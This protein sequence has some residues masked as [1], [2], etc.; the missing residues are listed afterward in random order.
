MSARRALSGIVACVI[1]LVAIWIASF[2]LASFQRAD[3][4]VFLAFYDLTYL[5]YP[6]RPNP[7]FSFL[8]SLCHALPYALIAALVVA[9]AL[10]R[11]Q[12]RAAC[13]A[14]IVLI[15]ANL[16]TLV[17]KA[18]L[19]EPRVATLVVGAPHVPY[20]RWPSGHSTAAMAVALA[21]VF[22]APARL[23]PVAAAAGGAFVALVADGLLVLGSHLPSDVLAGFLVAAGW[24][25]IALIAVFR[26]EH[27]ARTR[28]RHSVRAVTLG[29]SL[30]LSLSAGSLVLVSPEAIV[31]YAGGHGRFVAV[32]LGVAAFTIATCMAVAIVL[33]DVRRPASRA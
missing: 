4:H 1:L 30:P 31:P 7:A 12:P 21:L 22:V 33:S 11:G 14:A 6:G 16:T 28:R 18:L 3:Q 26:D 13:A 29:L 8:I 5:Y 25:L 24:S 19:P 27:G 10:G 17:L 2:H 15:G 32:A 20:P 23:R 9:F